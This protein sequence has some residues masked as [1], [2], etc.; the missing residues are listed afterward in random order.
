MTF[1][2]NGPE[3]MPT[4]KANAPKV[5]LPT[6]GEGFGAATSSSQLKTDSNFV[7]VRRR[8]ETRDNLATQ[9]VP[10]L[11]MDQI[12]PMFEARNAKAIE[13]GMPSQVV[14][15]PD[16]VE[17]AVALMGPNF[18]SKA[19]EMAR[20]AA[21]NDPE[22]WADVDLSDEAIEETMN[23]G[24]RKE[25]DDAQQIL[26]MMPSGRGSAEFLGEMVGMTADV[27]NLPFLFLGGGGGSIA[28]IAGRE[29]AINMAAEGAFIP[30]QFDMAERLEI[31]DPSVASQLAMAAGAGGI[32]GGSIAAAQRGWGYFRTR[33]DTPQIGR[34]DSVQSEAMVDAAEDILTSDA[35]NPLA[36]IGKLADEA[37]EDMKPAPYRLEN[38][39]NPE[40]PP[41]LEPTGGRITTTPLDPIDGSAAAPLSDAN[42]IETA[43]AGIDKA[44]SPK[45]K[46]KR[47]TSI[48]TFVVKE[49]GIWKGDD[50]GEIAGMEYKRPGFTKK[51]LRVASSAGDNNGGLRIDEMRERAIEQG[52]LPEGSSINDLLDALDADIRGTK[53]AYSQADQV[54]AEEWRAF[55]GEAPSEGRADAATSDD[56]PTDFQSAVED[57]EAMRPSPTYINREMMDASPDPESDIK[58]I[59]DGWLEESGWSSFLTPNEKDE[60]LATLQERGGDPDLLT[61]AIMGR[62][63]DHYE[64]PDLSARD[65]PFDPRDPRAELPSQGGEVAGRPQ[66]DPRETGGSRARGGDGEASARASEQTG[67]G[68]QTLIDGVAPVTVRD[69]LQAQQDAPLSGGNAAADDGLFDVSS[70]TQSDMFSDPSSPEARELQQAVANDMRTEIDADGDFD[71]SVTMPNGASLDMKATGLLDYLDDG[72]AFSARLDLC[73]AV[74]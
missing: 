72:D 2:L 7:K 32:L 62:E 68:D 5:D 9:V 41:L 21:R 1:F 16:N 34:M 70:R 24:F 63:L 61:S 33:N 25:Y 3:T 58:I 6:W 36:Q 64:A 40:R 53:R 45:P 35:P 13:Q 23:E 66:S 30:S 56:G 12:R 48:K 49:G 46:T 43:Q 55:D 37:G 65:A 29:A 59:F 71:L 31:P 15:I 20:D 52:F 38:P 39:L 17:D 26:E 60:I 54:L 50:T 51:E 73:G 27:K 69:R 8:I 22:A 18:S 4:I 74:E 57:Y 28:R 42:L 19:I 47:P 10:R 14:E 11:G 67:A 44:T